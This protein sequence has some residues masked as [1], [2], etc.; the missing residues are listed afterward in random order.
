[1]LIALLG[2]TPEKL[3]E[4]YVDASPITHASKATPPTL[5]LHGS[6][7]PLVLLEQAQVFEKK[8]KVEGVDVQLLTLEGAGH[9]GMGNNPHSVLQTYTA[10]LKRNLQPAR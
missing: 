6:A 7:D 4:L 3:P 10:F 8:L 9:G 2:D 5:L 1:M